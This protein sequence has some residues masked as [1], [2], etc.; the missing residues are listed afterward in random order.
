[1]AASPPRNLLD[2]QHGPDQRRWPCCCVLACHYC[3]SQMTWCI[4]RTPISPTAISWDVAQDRRMFCIPGLGSGRS[5][6]CQQTVF[7]CDFS[8][9]S[10]RTE[11]E[12]QRTKN[13]KFEAL[14]WAHVVSLAYPFYG[15]VF[16]CASVCEHRSSA[17]RTW[18]PHCC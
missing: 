17:A 5:I 10:S 2:A 11:N 4:I 13:A 8:D 1:M 12:F 7:F 3:I 16:W 14:D 6:G 15:C 18:R 9:L